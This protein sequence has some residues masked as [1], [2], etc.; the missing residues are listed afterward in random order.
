MKKI[1]Q[2]RNNMIW[3]KKK[4]NYKK[5]LRVHQCAASATTKAI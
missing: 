2:K 4:T 5:T 1:H 3:Q